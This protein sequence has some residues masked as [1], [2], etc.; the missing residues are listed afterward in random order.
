MV[1]RV[2]KQLRHNKRIKTVKVQ[3]LIQILTIID[4]ITSR[5]KEKM[6][7]LK[8]KE[9]IILSNKKK[10]VLMQQKRIE[11]QLSSLELFRLRS[12]DSIAFL[13]TRLKPRPLV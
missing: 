9:K 4:K 13:S 1:K 5:N 6:K 12:S 10:I 7:S 11:F 8:V 3:L 2:Q